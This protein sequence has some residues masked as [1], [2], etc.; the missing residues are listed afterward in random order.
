MERDGSHV[1]RRRNCLQLCASAPACNVRKVI[2][3]PARKPLPP[4]TRSHTDEMDIP[5][6]LRL[7]QEP[8][9]I[10]YGI[11]VLANDI[12]RV[13]KLPQEHWVVQRQRPLAA[14]ELRQIPKN[15]VE[16]GQ[17]AVLNLH[18]PA[19]TCSRLSCPGGP[20]VPCMTP[21]GRRKL[22][23]AELIEALP[24]ARELLGEDAYRWS[25]EANHNAVANEIES[26]WV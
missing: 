20:I 12:R 7:R 5:D 11:A 19:L 23:T 25:S 8:Q 4:V 24:E 6:G 10:G 26:A 14:P 1:I 17:R 22:T 21:T 9:Q 18:H 3:K 13:S 2:V 16:V 15:L